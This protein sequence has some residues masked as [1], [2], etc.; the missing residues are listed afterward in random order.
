MNEGH[1]VQVI[2]PV[3]DVAFE[4]GKLPQIYNALRVTNPAVDD[5]EWNLVLEVAQHVGDNTVRTVAMDTTDG[6]VRGMKVQD[7]G[8]A[9][10]V[11]VGNAVL[12]R[13]VNVVG[14]PMDHR[15]AWLLLPSRGKT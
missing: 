10:T 5:R 15:I 13:I 12:G 7:T 4:P 1:I 2:G 14:E 3:V 8:A 6:L 11:P 9:I